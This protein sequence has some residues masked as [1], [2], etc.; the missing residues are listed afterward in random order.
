MQ[1]KLDRNCWVPGKHAQFPKSSVGIVDSSNTDLNSAWMAMGLRSVF[2]ESTIIVKWPCWSTAYSEWDSNQLLIQKHWSS[3]MRIIIQFGGYNG[4]QQEG[5]HWI[6]AT[7]IFVVNNSKQSQ[8]LFKN[9]NLVPE[10]KNPKQLLHVYSIFTHK[11]KEVTCP[12][13]S[14]QHVLFLLDIDSNNLTVK[15]SNYCLDNYVN[16]LEN[17]TLLLTVP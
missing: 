8:V 14:K 16:S 9:Q 4:G 5:I 13:P 7:Y 15:P 12:L 17:M 10:A 1:A 11:K 3:Q 2:D 6:G